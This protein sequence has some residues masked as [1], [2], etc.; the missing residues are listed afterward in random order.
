MRPKLKKIFYI[1]LL[2]IIAL[3]FVVALQ[4]KNILRCFY[5]IEYGSHIVSYSK[6]YG[7]DSYLICALINVESHYDKDAESHKDAKGLMQITV[8]TGNWA[9]EKIGIKNFNDSMLYDPNV[10]IRIG[11]WYLN[12][13]KK[14]FNLGEE[15]TDRVL[16]LAAYNGG[17]GNVKKWLSIKE[18]SPT[19]TTLDLIPFKE[20]RDYVKKVLRDYKIYRWLYTDI[21]KMF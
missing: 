21:D 9:A 4:Y 8:S 20:T 12:S 17:S 10:N 6:E 5:P 11:C 13:L 16:M 14:E 19:G 1:C 18:Y 2:I 3:F 15:E 7:L